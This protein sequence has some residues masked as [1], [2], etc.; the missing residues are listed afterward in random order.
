MRTIQFFFMGL[1]ISMSTVMAPATADQ[2]E[3]YY[4]ECFT[5]HA[6][7]GMSI[8][9]YTDEQCRAMGGHSIRNGGICFEI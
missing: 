2:P 4:G 1:L 5:L 8:G 9:T 3:I 6:C 7:E